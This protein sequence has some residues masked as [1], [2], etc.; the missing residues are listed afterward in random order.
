LGISRFF[1]A[2]KTTGIYCRPI[3]PA[4]TPARNRCRFFRHAAQA[5]QAGFRPCLRCR[6]ELA[7]G[8]GPLDEPGRLARLVAAKIEGGALNEGRSID[9]LAGE[10]GLSSRQL[11][12]LVQR[13]YGVSPVE[14]ARTNRLLLAKQLLTETPLPIINVAFASGFESLRRFNAAFRAHYKLTPS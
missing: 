6:P 8:V 5:E 13:E 2:V 7:S 12:R 10:L 3:C 14:L 9:T 1:V 4:R 11:R